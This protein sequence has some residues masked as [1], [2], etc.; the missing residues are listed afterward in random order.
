MLARGRCGAY[1]FSRIPVKK[2]DNFALSLL[3]FAVIQ[4]VTVKT[5]PSVGL[6]QRE[7]VNSTRRCSLSTPFFYRYFNGLTNPMRTRLATELFHLVVA[8]VLVCK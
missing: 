3:V 6:I 1:G 4:F 5:D 7:F 2:A 8:L